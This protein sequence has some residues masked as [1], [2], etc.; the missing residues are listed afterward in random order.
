MKKITV[1][2]NT[3]TPLYTG[4]AWGEC[5]EIKPS[6]IMGSLRFWFEVYCHFAGIKVKEK[7]ELNYKKFIEKRKE[8]LDKNE[9]EILNELGI[10]C[11]SRIFGC[12]GWK[13]RIEIKRIDFYLDDNYLYPIWKKTLYS[14][15][16]KKIK[17]GK[18]SEIIPSWYFPKGFFGNFQIIFKTTEEINENILLPLLRFIENYGFIGGKNNLGYGRIKIN[19]INGEK[20]DLNQYNFDLGIIKC[21]KN[22]TE[23]IFENIN[24]FDDLNENKIQIIQVNFNNNDLSSLIKGLIKKKAEYRKAISNKF[25]RHYKF[26]STAKDKY[27]DIQGPNATKIIP[28]ITKNENGKYVGNFLSI[29][30]IK[31]FGDE[32]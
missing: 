25:E 28:L 26:G 22:I 32:R 7:E 1:S 9:F 29:W 31:N 4:D 13:S 23:E 18:E 15:R 16:Y 30:G 12:T 24:N 17:N 8:N 11:S 21:N 5:K 27:N 20:I 2:F 10:T 14:L 6:A 3:I 19:K